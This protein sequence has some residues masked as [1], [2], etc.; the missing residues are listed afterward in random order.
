M[1]ELGELER[2]H[3]DFDRRNV[4]VYAISPDDL[5]GAQV[6]QKD[7]PHL[8]I[9]SDS[10]M[11]VARAIGTVHP[12]AGHGG[13]DTNAPTTILVDGK[14]TVRWLERRGNFFERIPPDEVLAAIDANSKN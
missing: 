8:K 5:P 13:G 4:R 7:F 9:V 3:E 14:G 10:K 6:V 1:V 2:R 12:G 11:D